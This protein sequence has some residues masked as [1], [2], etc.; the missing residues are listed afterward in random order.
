MLHLG[1]IRRMVKEIAADNQI[2]DA[3]NNEGFSGGPLF[4]YPLGKPTELRV[5]GVVSKFRVE[6][7]AALDEHG[8]ATTMTVPYNTGFLVAYGIKHALDLIQE[9]TGNRPNKAT[10]EVPGST[11]VE[12]FLANKVKESKP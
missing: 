8:N 6:H 5:A 9:T 12:L 11:G 2:D 7:E 10:T 3:I 1:Y 4:F